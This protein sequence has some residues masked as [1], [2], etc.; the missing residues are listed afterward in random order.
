MPVK[1]Y[2]NSQRLTARQ[3]EKSWLIFMRAQDSTWLALV[4][5]ALRA[6]DKNKVCWLVDWLSI[7]QWMCWI[8]L[9]ITQVPYY[10]VSYCFNKVDQ[11][12]TLL[13]L[14]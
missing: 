7:E 9:K 3:H 2:A 12:G 10:L 14:I 6:A 13:L 4:P 5:C 8:L 11:T 1:E